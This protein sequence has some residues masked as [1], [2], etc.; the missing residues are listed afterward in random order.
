MEKQIKILDEERRGNNQEITLIA[1]SN[2]N[3]FKKINLLALEKKYNY[4]NYYTP[5]YPPTML[6]LPLKTDTGSLSVT[7]CA[8]GGTAE[9]CNEAF[10]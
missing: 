10:T 5:I 9:L 6:P 7:K 3:K 8:G 4:A 1:K 2:K